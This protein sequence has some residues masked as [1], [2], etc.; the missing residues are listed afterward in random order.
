MEKMPYR[1]DLD[2]TLMT[3]TS[4]PTP[5]VTSTDWQAGPP[6]LCGKQVVLR[7][8]HVGCRIALHVV[9][10]REVSRFISLP[11]PRSKASNASSRTIRQSTAGAYA[12]THHAA[13][14]RHAIGIFRSV[15][16]TRPSRTRNGLRDRVGT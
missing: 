4:T 9:D 13:G 11:R 16:S 8:A 7:A 5:E 14:F 15:S 3:V 2:V 6:T 1:Q 10:D 12:A